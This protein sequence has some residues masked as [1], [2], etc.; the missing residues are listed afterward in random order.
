MSLRLRPLPRGGGKEKR[1]GSGEGEEAREGGL[2]STEGFVRDGV[3][4][5]AEE[6]SDVGDGVEFT[7]EGDGESRR[8]KKA[9]RGLGR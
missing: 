9:K 1:W 7:C 5:S 6:P 3:G 8:G 2:L 4:G